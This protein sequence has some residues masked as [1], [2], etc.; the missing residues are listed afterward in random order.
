MKTF[1][2]TKKLALLVVI[3]LS[4]I[5]SYGVFAQP[6]ASATN[7]RVLNDG[8]TYLLTWNIASAPD[9]Y[10]IILKEG[11]PET[12]LPSNGTTYSA[13]QSFGGGTVFAVRS[14]GS[15][16]Y[17]FSKGALPTAGQDYYL[18]IYPYSTSGGVKYRTTEPGIAIFVKPGV[19][20]SEPNQAT[21]LDL[22]EGTILTTTQQINYTF[23]PSSN[24]AGVPF[25]TKYLIVGKFGST[26]SFTPSDGVSIT[27]STTTKADV[28]NDEFALL[29]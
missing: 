9:G 8:P 29:A 12:S 24:E 19:V 2:P 20:N 5:S 6:S 21:N 22:S 3:Y 23:D 25:Q 1:K 11:S 7:A 14:G 16:Q 28:G 18:T 10:L 26:P 13:G 27:T 15:T 17:G 4:L